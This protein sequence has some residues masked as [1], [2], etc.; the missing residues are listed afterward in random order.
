MNLTFKFRLKNKHSSELNRQARKVNFVWNYCNE[1]QQKAVR[2]DRKWLNYYDLH[3][4]TKGSSKELNICSQTIQHVCRQYDRS[5]KQHKKPWLKFRGIKSLGWIP[6]NKGYVKLLDNKKFCFR[7]KI[8]ETMHWRE[9]PEGS[10]ICSGSFNQD[11]RGRWYINVVIE[12]PNNYFPKSK[13]SSIGIDLGLNNLATIS[14]GE[15]IETLKFYRQYEKEL[16][17]AQRAGKK[18]QVRNISAK[19]ANCRKDYLHKTS[20][21]LALDNDI[22][23][24]GKLPSKKM[25]RTR[26]AKS[27]LDAGWFML[28][29]QLSYKAIRH[30]GRYVEVDEAYTTQTCSNCYSVCGPKGIAGLEIRE[31]TCGSCGSI[32]DRDINAAINILRLGSET[33]AEGAAKAE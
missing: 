21:R 6:F 4:L 5:R 29:N 26:M 12:V 10:V 11:R 33:L 25:A 20:A 13:K 16:G 19:I 22:I 3:K 27:V 2:S 15:K 24:V 9:I 8:Y 14:S 30:G 31:W 7:K 28:R 17:M 32:H 18:R 23:V 1:T